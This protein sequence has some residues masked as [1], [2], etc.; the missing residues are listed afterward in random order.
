MEWKAIFWSLK[1]VQVAL[2][3][4]HITH[5]GFFLRSLSKHLSNH[6]KNTKYFRTRLGYVIFVT[7]I[8]NLTMWA[9]HKIGQFDKGKRISHF[10]LIWLDVAASY[11]FWKRFLNNAASFLLSV[12]VKKNSSNSIKYPFL[13]QGFWR[14]YRSVGLPSLFFVIFFPTHVQKRDTTVQVSWSNNRGLPSN[15]CRPVIHVTKSKPAP[16]W[17]KKSCSFNECRLQFLLL[18]H[19]GNNEAVYIHNDKSW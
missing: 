1:W 18:W 7:F 13:L 19:H 12:N 10:F 6:T 4:L 14:F 8:S 16:F 17:G 3:A 15:E 9:G 2:V 5:I 11:C